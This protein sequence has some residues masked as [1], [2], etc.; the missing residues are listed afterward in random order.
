M[1]AATFGHVSRSDVEL[2][3]G[4]QSGDGLSPSSGG[5]GLCRAY[6]PGEGSVVLLAAIS[7]DS[8][9]AGAGFCKSE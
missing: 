6:R 5:K 8:L 7:R 3:R 9:I 4:I 1:A 2:C